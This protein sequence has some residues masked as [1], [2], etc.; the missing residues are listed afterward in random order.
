MRSQQ[1][2]NQGKK[3]Q[4]ANNDANSDGEDDEVNKKVNNIIK[5]FQSIKNIIEIIFNFMNKY[6]FMQDKLALSFFDQYEDLHG[7][8]K[9][10]M[11]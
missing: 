3:N 5:E 9:V 4:Q 2:L 8:I 6:I 1:S 11:V 7:L 10:L